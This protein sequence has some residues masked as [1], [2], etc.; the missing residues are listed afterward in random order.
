MTSGSMVVRLESDRR[1][2]I[3]TMPDLSDYLGGWEMGME[4]MIDDLPGLLMRNLTVYDKVIRY[5]SATD[6]DK[7][8]S[9]R[10]TGRVVEK[11]W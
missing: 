4:G 6:V 11:T 9:G 5:V 10:M 8:I 1:T 3:M 2:G 7:A